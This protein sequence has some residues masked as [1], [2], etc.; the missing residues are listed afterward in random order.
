M[1]NYRFNRI[2]KMRSFAESPAKKFLCDGVLVSRSYLEDL[3]YHTLDR[4]IRKG[5]VQSA[6]KV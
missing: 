4:L 3:P 2:S 6:Q 5:K 1:K